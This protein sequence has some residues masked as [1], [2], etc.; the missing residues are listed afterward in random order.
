VTAFAV[1]HP[2]GALGYR[3]AEPKGR[4]GALVYVSDNELAGHERYGS[5]SDW[6]QRMVEFVREAGV[7]IHD[8]TYTTEEYDHHRGWGHSTFADAVELALEA[9]VGTLVLFHH[10]PRRTDDQL[11]QCLAQCRATVQDRGGTL[12]VIAAAEGLTLTL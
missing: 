7:L 9:Q 12:Q 10:E 6:R 4:G 2:G 8:T 3:F 5:P 1:Q 11:E